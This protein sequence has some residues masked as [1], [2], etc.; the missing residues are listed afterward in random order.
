MSTCTYFSLRFSLRFIRP[1]QFA[2]FECPLALTLAYVLAYVLSGQNILRNLTVHQMALSSV[3]VICTW[4]MTTGDL[5]EV[6]RL[7]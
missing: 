5:E 2:Q 3:S 7:L 1:E 6:A 4:Q